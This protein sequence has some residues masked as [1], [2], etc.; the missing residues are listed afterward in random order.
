MTIRFLGSVSRAIAL[1]PKSTWDLSTR[2]LRSCFNFFLS[3]EVETW[4]TW[5]GDEIEV[6]ISTIQAI[7]LEVKLTLIF[8]YVGMPQKSTFSQSHVKI[9]LDCGTLSS[10]KNS[11]LS[12]FFLLWSWSRVLMTIRPSVY[13]KLICFYSTTSIWPYGPYLFFNTFFPFFPIYLPSKTGELEIGSVVECDGEMCVIY[14]K[15][16]RKRKRWPTLLYVRRKKLKLPILYREVG[17]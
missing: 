15:T 1:H 10:H 11:L 17:A 2:R 3:H 12:A 4:L 6:N 14:R 13:Q 16:R 8:D 7:T 9:M 5:V